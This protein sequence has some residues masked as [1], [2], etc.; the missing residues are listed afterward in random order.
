MLEL[1]YEN[2]RKLKDEKTAFYVER[3]EK[4][5]KVIGDIIRE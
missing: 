4:N 1:L 2:V 3:C 5:V